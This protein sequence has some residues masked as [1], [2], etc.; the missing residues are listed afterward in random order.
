M[1]A[2]QNLRIKTRDGNMIGTNGQ[3]YGDLSLDNTIIRALES[4]GILPN[5]KTV[6]RVERQM[7]VVI[8]SDHSQTFKKTVRDS[9]SKLTDPN[10]HKV[11]WKNV[12]LN[13]KN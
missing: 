2:D 7:Q 3:K 13:K 9:F 10:G 4:D 12:S 8:Q 5:R 6:E 1:N 11:V